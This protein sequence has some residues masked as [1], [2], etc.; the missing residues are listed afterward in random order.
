MLT[1]KHVSLSLPQLIQVGKLSITCRNGLCA[2]VLGND[3]RKSGYARTN[4]LTLLVIIIDSINTTSKILK[5]LTT[6]KHLLCSTIYV[7]LL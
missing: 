5:L 6:Y 1:D 4:H 3:P 2:L 7:Y